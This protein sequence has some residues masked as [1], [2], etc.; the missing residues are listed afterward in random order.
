MS[1][2]KERSKLVPMPAWQRRNV[3]WPTV[4]FFGGVVLV[5]A[6]SWTLFFLFRGPMWV[7]SPLLNGVCVYACFTIL[8]EAAHRNIFRDRDSYGNDILGI[9]AGL[10]MH[11]SFEQFIGIHLKH[12][13]SV[14]DPDQDPDFHARGPLHPA[15][16]VRW[17]FTVPHY[18]TEFKRLGLAR[19]R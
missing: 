3:E 4:V 16:L 18:F 8:H 1:T 7:V 2:E 19:G 15:R 9:F 10:V 6:S 5:L 11:G 17:I 14:N 12:H 13:A